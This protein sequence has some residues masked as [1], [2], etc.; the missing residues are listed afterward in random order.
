MQGSHRGLLFRTTWVKQAATNFGWLAVERGVRLA[1]SVVVGFW[2][3]RHL[4]PAEFGVLNYCLALVGLLGFLPALGLDQVVRREL[5]LRPAEANLL[6]V[7]AFSLRLV[8]GLVAMGVL[9]VALVAGGRWMKAE[10]Q[11]LV[12]VLSLMLFQP[13]LTAPDLWL[14]ATLQAKYTTVAQTLSLVVGAVVRIGLILCNAALWTFAAVVVMEMLVA[15][16]GLWWLGRRRGLPFRLTGRIDGITARALLSEAWPLMFASLAIMIYMRIDAVMLRQMLGP[17][18]VGIYSAAVRISEIWYFI[19]VA[20]ASS[21]LPALLHKRTGSEVAYQRGLQQYFDLNAAIAYALAVP[22][23][24]MSPWVIRV[25]YGPAYAGAAGVL[26]VHI[27]SSVFVFLGVARGQ[28]LVNEKMMRFYLVT[29]IVG[30]IANVA[31]N[32]VLIPRAG[33]LGAA[34]AT[35]VSYALAVWFSSLIYPP[36]RAIGRIQTRALLL[37]LLG[38]RYFRST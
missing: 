25:A 19:P 34:W 26:A 10:E 37:P 28:W 36:A 1:L 9:A 22:I 13:A 23:G 18:A 2:V 20:L 5:I 31:L 21:L 27:W 6:M 12:G 24:L 33:P 32:L 16:A 7:N 8:G 4:G 14:Q 17:A 15:S 29:T 35:V 38:W 30:A 3:A 11:L